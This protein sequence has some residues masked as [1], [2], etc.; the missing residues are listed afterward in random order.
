[1]YQ[2]GEEVMVWWK[3]D[4]A[5]G[6]VIEIPHAH[7]YR[8]RLADGEVVYRLESDLEKWRANR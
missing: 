4:Y 5:F 1:M 2:V 8:V 7:C 6:R 3:G